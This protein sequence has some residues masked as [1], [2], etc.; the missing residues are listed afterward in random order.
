[1]RD[2]YFTKTEVQGMLRCNNNKF[3]RV[4]AMPG[5]FPHFRVGVRW[6]IPKGK[7]FAWYDGIKKS[8]L[9]YQLFEHDYRLIMPD[10]EQQRMLY[11][12]HLNR[13][14]EHRHNLRRNYIIT[15]KGERYEQVYFDR[16][17]GR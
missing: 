16:P 13:M 8:G 12:A 1:M 14:A 7:F 6:V 3:A 15:A 2:D 4:I 11:N 9:L 5:A 17:S 10:V